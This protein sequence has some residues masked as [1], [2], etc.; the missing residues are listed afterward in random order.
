MRSRTTAASEGRR[1]TALLLATAALAC[2]GAP[3]GVVPAAPSPAATPP[4]IA[5]RLRAAIVTVRITR[6]DWN[7]KTPWTKHPPF[8]LGTVGLVLPGRRIL[9]A[10][11]LSG[12]D[13]LVE[14]GRSGDPARTP[15]RVALL[16]LEGPLGLLEVEDPAFWEGLEP[17]PFADPLPSE[18]DVTIHYWEREL[19]SSQAGAIRQVRSGR[20]GSSRT[21]LLTLDVAVRTSGTAFGVVVWEGRVAGLVPTATTGEA[22]SAIASPVLAQFARDAA[23]GD[24]RGFA[25][26]GIEFQELT[27]PALREA[28]G[29]GPDEGGVRITSVLPHGSAAGL[30]GPGDVVLELG[31]VKIDSTGRYEHPLYGRLSVG[32]L[33][34]DGRRPGDGVDVAILRD[35]ERL[36]LG[37]ALR[38]M[39]P[40]LDKVPPY[41]AGAGPDY[42]IA[43]GLVF[44]ELTAEYLATWNDWRRRAPP[45]LIVAVEREGALPTPE[46]PRIVLLTSVLPDAANLGYQH[47][48]DLIVERVNGREIGSMAD[49]RQAFAAAPDGFH[50]IEFLPGQTTRRIV[51]DVAEAEASIPR[52][53]T[54]YG[55]DLMD[56]AARRP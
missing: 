1:A 33:L 34:T 51:I 9:V 2:A 28:L 7:W 48:Q 16:D 12:R 26:A 14:V 13:V 35:G 27:N 20:H 5:A 44:Q 22:V 45:R 15:A 50:V 36:R 17:L 39:A 6:Q 10:G 4:A 37:M 49:L 29:L 30:L 3:R 32:V 23:S 47:L 56:S 31:G 43:G 41:D 19:L 8:T 38:S 21:N 54:A 55:V 53:R 24:H 40:E 18:G 25:R 46:R 11:G 52:I 42:V